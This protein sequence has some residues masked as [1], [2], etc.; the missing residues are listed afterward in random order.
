V[1]ERLP[2][3]ADELIGGDP[4]GGSTGGLGLVPTPEGVGETSAAKL[5]T[6]PRAHH[7][8]L[9]ECS[10]Y[11]STEAGEKLRAMLAMGASRPWPD[12]LEAISGERSM[13][14]SALI[15]YFAPLSSWIEEQNEGRTC[16]W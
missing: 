8:T 14:A 9:H 10:I 16:G 4:A 1:R 7:A 5:G 2:L 6:G 3:L 12:A 13:D 11:G 15:E